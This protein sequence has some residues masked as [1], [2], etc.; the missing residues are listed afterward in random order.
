M[1]NEILIA[2]LDTLR[3]TYTQQQKAVATLQAAF[4]G[5]TNANSKAQKAFGTSVR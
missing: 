4:K 5:V 3:E 1:P 2:Q